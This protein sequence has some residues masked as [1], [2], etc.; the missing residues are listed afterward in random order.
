MGIL[1][2]RPGPHPI[3]TVHRVGAGSNGGFLV[4]FG[5]L[6]LSRGLALLGP[7]GSPVMGLSTNG[8]LSAISLVVGAAL[9]GSAVRGGPTASTISI[10]VGIGFLISAA[11]NG[12]VLGSPMNVLAFTLPNV[13]FSGVVGTVLLVLGSYGRVS[14]SLPPDNPY[15]AEPASVAERAVD[16][17][18]DPAA[19]R[20][21]ADAERARAL[22]RATPEQTVR[23]NR[24]DEH[25]AH[26]DRQRRW[27]ASEASDRRSTGVGAEDPLTTS[28]PGP[29]RHDPAP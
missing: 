9:I 25:R 10:V 17:R 6:G 12:F 20:E 3:H 7:V 18:L 22:R 13:V 29:A 2:P 19:A 5:V 11:A 8:L 21:L 1:H 4:V 27:R 24:V 16:G 28:A 14:G 23:L 26:G 15:A